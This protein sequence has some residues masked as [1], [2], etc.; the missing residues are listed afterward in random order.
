LRMVGC[1]VARGP[2][3]AAGRVDDTK[4]ANARDEVVGLG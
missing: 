1:R 3:D 2:V 4:D